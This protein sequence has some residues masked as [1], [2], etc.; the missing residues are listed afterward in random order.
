MAFMNPNRQYTPG[1]NN[2]K[3]VLS[4]AV[5]GKYMFTKILCRRYLKITET[6]KFRYFA[7]NPENKPPRVLDRKKYGPYYMQ[8]N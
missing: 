7:E 4:L 6:I 3:F 8:Q 2:G 5:F 1:S